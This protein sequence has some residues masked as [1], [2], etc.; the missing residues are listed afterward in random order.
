MSKIKNT[1]GSVPNTLGVGSG[2]VQME[3]GLYVA[4]YLSKLAFHFMFR[5]I[6]LSGVVSSATFAQDARL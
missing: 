2:A 6:C 1:E 4:G 3:Y 5:V